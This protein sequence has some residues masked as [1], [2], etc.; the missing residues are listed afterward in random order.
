[1]I[2]TQQ[3]T[4]QWNQIRGKVKEKWGQLTDDDLKVVGGNVDQVIGRIQQRTGELRSDIEDFLSDLMSEPRLRQAADTAK[5]YVQSAADSMREGYQQVS[6]QA[7]E[8]F[9]GARDL[10]RD[11]PAQSMAAVFAA[12]ALA[13]ICFGLLMR[14]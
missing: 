2:N 14:D 7:Q 4:G 1:M 13:G 9:E 6:Q 12:G 8:G 5:E 11:R 3:L 10:V